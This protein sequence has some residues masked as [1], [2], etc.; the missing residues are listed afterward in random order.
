M[1]VYNDITADR[2]VAGRLWT[3]AL[4]FD[5]MSRDWSAICRPFSWYHVQTQGGSL[6]SSFVD[7]GWALI[8]EFPAFTIDESYDPGMELRLVFD[9]ES[10]LDAGGY[11]YRFTEAGSGVTSNEVTVTSGWT[12]DT[13]TMTW[14]VDA[15]MPSGETT[16][17]FQIKGNPA[18]DIPGGDTMQMRR[19][20]AENTAYF[21]VRIV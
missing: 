1:A 10:L 21:Q 12:T 16:L 6:S 20:D 8:M 2:L 17:Q 5:L 9:F 11:E 19:L 7:G 14:D 15:T 18:N 4:S 3:P 13:I